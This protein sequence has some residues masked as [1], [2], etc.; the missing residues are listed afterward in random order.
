[1]YLNILTL[2]QSYSLFISW[3]LIVSA[4]LLET[5]F[6][7]FIRLWFGWPGWFHLKANS[8]WSWKRFGSPTL[9]KFSKP[10]KAIRTP[11]MI[12]RVDKKHRIHCWLIF[13]QKYKGQKEGSKN[14]VRI[15]VHITFPQCLELRAIQSI[16]MLVITPSYTIDILLVPPSQ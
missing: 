15:G 9:N 12:A 1:M 13:R 14:I 4:D 2:S 5:E 10:W 3:I 6:L 16:V 7:F 8:S 11:K